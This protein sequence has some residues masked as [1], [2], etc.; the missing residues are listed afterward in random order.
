MKVCSVCGKKYPDEANFCPRATCATAGRP[1]RLT[2]AGVEVPELARRQMRQ[3]ARKP[4]ADDSPARLRALAR[5]RPQQ[6]EETALRTYLQRLTT[7]VGQ[8]SMRPSDATV[9]FLRYFLPETNRHR[10]EP[11]ERLRDWDQRGAPSDLQNLRH[12]AYAA[13]V[14]RLQERDEPAEKGTISGAA[15]PRRRTITSQSPAAPRVTGVRFQAFFD[16]SKPREHPHDPEALKSMNPTQM[17]MHVSML[18]QAAGVRDVSSWPITG[19]HGADLLFSWQG[20][21]VVVQ[22]KGAG[23]SPAGRVLREAQAARAAY[24]CQAV[25]IVTAASAPRALRTAASE[26]HVLLVDGGELEK[27][28][29]LITQQ[30]RLLASG[31]GKRR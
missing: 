23:G 12:R 25:W 27:L 7:L 8:R 26:A 29:A 31:N 1:R 9:D 13:I 14:A 16:A 6:S 20:K 28:E 22:T 5:E 18:L 24:G 4:G 3:F 11:G 10:P 15:R 19:D 21:K 2:L 17:A 30:L